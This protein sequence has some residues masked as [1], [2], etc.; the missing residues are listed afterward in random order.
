[1]RRC[2]AC[3]IDKSIDEFNKKGARLQSV[4]KRCN[5][6]ILKRHYV[7]N[8]LKYKEKK[9]RYY[10]S[11]REYVNLLKTPCI[12]CGESD[13]R[14]LDFHHI[15]G[16]EVEIAIAVR[17]GWSKERIKIEIDKCVILC[18]NCHRKEHSP[19]V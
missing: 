6:D 17:R 7:N 11:V 14:C 18:A 10:N 12:N 1:M 15:L 4:C 13:I 2:S 5:R 16:K 3:K 9:K 19:I 8:K